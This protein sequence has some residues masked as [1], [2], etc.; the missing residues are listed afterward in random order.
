MI[1]H[2]VYAEICDDTVQNIMV[3]DNYEMANYISR[4][5]YGDQAFAVDCLQY[6]CSIGDKYHSGRFWHIDEEGNETEVV[7]VPTAEEEV[8]I[9]R[10]ETDDLTLAMAAMI[11]GV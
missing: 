6:P 3:C 7:Y 2:Q 4:A 9:L 10:G 1:V 8:Q 11:G 5:T